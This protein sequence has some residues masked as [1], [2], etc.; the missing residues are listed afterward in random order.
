MSAEQNST[1]L[2]IYLT[3]IVL[4]IMIAAFVVINAWR[5]FRPNPKDISYIQRHRETQGS[6]N[7]TVRRISGLS[8]L[9]LCGLSDLTNWTRMYAVTGSDAHGSEQRFYYAVD[10]ITGLRKMRSSGTWHDV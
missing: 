7:I 10:P 8:R 2:F 6:S 3:C 4:L 1:W 9:W 5:S